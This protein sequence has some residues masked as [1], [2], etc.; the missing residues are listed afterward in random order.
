MKGIFGKVSMCPAG[1]DVRRLDAGTSSS[2][3]S[4]R[5]LGQSAIPRMSETL[6]FEIQIYA[7]D[8]YGQI[9]YAV[10]LLPYGPTRGFQDTQI[11]TS[12]VAVAWIF[13]C[14]GQIVKLS[15]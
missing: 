10:P 1:A 2:P 9:V 15:T 11:S 12:T 5:L 13:L 14:T 8:D 6:L 3:G 7:K 4:I